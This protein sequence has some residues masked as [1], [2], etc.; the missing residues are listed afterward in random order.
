MRKISL[1]NQGAA[2]NTHLVMVTHV[3][4]KD[5]IS[6]TND[7]TPL[8]AEPCSKW[9]SVCSTLDLNSAVTWTSPA[10]CLSNCIV[11]LANGSRTS[12][13]MQFEKSSGL[14]ERKA[15]NAQALCTRRLQRSFGRRALYSPSG[16]RRATIAMM[17]NARC[18]VRGWI[19]K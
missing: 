6:L 16:C 18:S 1:M 8:S 4:I 9:C 13:M 2:K 15:A 11:K 19:S 12:C 10:L 5:T 7:I 14:W 17:Y 3:V